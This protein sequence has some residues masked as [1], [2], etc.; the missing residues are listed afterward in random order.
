MNICIVFV[1]IYTTEWQERLIF[2]VESSIFV[3]LEL[4]S[5]KTKFELVA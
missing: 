4:N 5:E 1:D 3:S 2:V